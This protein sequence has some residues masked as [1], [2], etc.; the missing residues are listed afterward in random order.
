[1][2]ALLTYFKIPLVVLVGIIAYL[3]LTFFHLNSIAIVIAIV[4]TALGSYDLFA[5]TFESLREKK[6]ALD[7]IA[8]LA[9]VTSF[10]TGQFLVAAVIALMLSSGRT[11]ED[12]GV[13]KAQQSLTKLAERIPD[14]VTLWKDGHADARVRLRDVAVGQ[15]VLIRKGEVVVLDGVLVSE[16]ASLDESTMTGEAAFV[17]KIAGD[18]VTSGTVN[19]GDAL[20][21]RATR[22]EADSTYRKIVEMVRSAQEEKSPL[23]RLADKYSMVFTLVT[24][25][26]SAVAYVLSHGDLQRVLAVL[27]V[28]TPCPL[29]LATPIALL[30]G[31]NAAS[32]QRIIVKKLAAIEVL[33]RVRAVIFDKTGTI[34][35]GRPQLAAF[36]NTSSGRTDGE[37][38]AIAESIER[39]SLHPLAKTLVAAAKE[40]GAEVLHATEVKEQ[41]GH[42]ISGMVAGRRY[43][44]AKPAVA[45]GMVIA[46]YEGDVNGRELGRFEFADEI[47]DDSRRVLHELRDRG[48]ELFVFTGDKQAA[49]DKVA[50]QL[51]AGVQVKAECTPADKQQG[52]RAI[53]ERGGVVAMVGDGINDAPALALADVG[54]VFSNEEQT[55]ASEAA[56]VVFLGGNLSQVL[57][58]IRISKHTIRIAMQSILWGIGMSVVAMLVAA[59]GVIPPVGGAFIQEAIDVIVILNALR[60]VSI[61]R[62]QS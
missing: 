17:D 1:M 44:L 49:A 41:I 55:A 42:G 4:V 2:T 36:H 33:A 34:T 23:V 57:D 29:I 51:D 7:Y 11:L 53:Q 46:L 10:I 45:A 38:F 27:V 35:L 54:M 28:A 15:E 18:P 13:S 3:S 9:I 39:N 32:R 19:Q 37:L 12:Y 21:M 6:Y 26:I 60:A 14:E 22:V 16:A 61:G 5:E 25:V 62:Q 40:R 56:D 59:T 43:T 48:L 47:K 24:L 30:A 8:I 58:A 50:A 20:V 31:V 52:I